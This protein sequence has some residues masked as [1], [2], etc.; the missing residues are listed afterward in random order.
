MIEFV[1][2]M[3]PSQG[4]AFLHR[5]YVRR[6]VRRFG[7]AAK[8][9]SQVLREIRESGAGSGAGSGSSRGGIRTVELWTSD[10]QVRPNIISTRLLVL[11]KA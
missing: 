2:R 10:A 1:V 11:Y 8:L 4:V 3:C 9:W 5:V 7:V 6:E